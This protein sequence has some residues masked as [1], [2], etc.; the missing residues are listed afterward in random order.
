MFNEIIFAT[1][2]E[3][4]LNEI[5]D[6]LK[7]FDVEVKSLKDFPNIPDI[8][9][10]GLT[11]LEN[12]II[13]AKTVYEVTKIPTLA[14]DSG[15]CV[16]FL[17]GMPGIFSSR[18]AGREA[19]DELNIKKLLYLMKNVL[20]DERGAYF[21][22]VMTFI[23]DDGNMITTSGKVDGFITDAPKGENGFGYDP[24]F[25]L[26]KYY[27]TMAQIDPEKKNHISH[28]FKAMIG[29]KKEFSDR[30]LFGYK[31]LI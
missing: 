5:K 19:T 30:Y 8:K 21:K 22:C 14:D 26:P 12:S 24:V 1:K 7:D 11:F 6:I 10:T 13:K 18:F 23:Y 2:N 3:G 9:E 17:D 29:M 28:R 31:E 16:N 27:L 20:K 15:L 25:Y 4:K